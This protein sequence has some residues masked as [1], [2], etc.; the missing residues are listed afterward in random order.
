M[1]CEPASTSRSVELPP[2]LPSQLRWGVGSRIGSRRSWCASQDAKCAAPGSMQ[3]RDGEDTPESRRWLSLSPVPSIRIQSISGPIG[4]CWSPEADGAVDCLSC[5]VADLVEVLVRNLI[6][7]LHHSEQRRTRRVGGGYEAQARSMRVVVPASSRRR[8]K[9]ISNP[10][11]NVVSRRGSA[12]T[13]TTTAA[14]GGC[15]D[16][17]AAAGCGCDG[18]QNTADGVCGEPPARLPSGSSADRPPNSSAARRA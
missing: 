8:S 15:E 4:C 6:V 16:G 17:S 11:S 2:L 7:V 12:T 9:S 10:K 18:V 5:S 13:T 1:C 14:A 3:A